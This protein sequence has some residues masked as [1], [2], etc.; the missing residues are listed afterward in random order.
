MNNPRAQVRFAASTLG[1]TALGAHG[2]MTVGAFGVKALAMIGAM[3]YYNNRFHRDAERLAPDYIRGKPHMIVTN[4]MTGNPAYVSGLGGSQ[5][6]LA[7]FGLDN[8]MDLAGPVMNGRMTVNDA[9][10]E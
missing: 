4:P 9:M 6:V 10:K 8:V 7:W 3:D 1:K 2:L 5:D